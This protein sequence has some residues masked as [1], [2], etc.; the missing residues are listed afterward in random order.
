MREISA[1]M[2]P[3]ERH[4]CDKE[5]CRRIL[6]LSEYRDAKNIFVYVSISAEV[7]TDELILSML[8]DGKNVFVPLC[9]VGGAMEAVKISDVSELH[10][11]LYGIC[12]PPQDNEHAHPESLDIIIVPAVAYSYGGA[13]LGRGG[14]YYDRYINRAKGVTTIGVCR[15]NNLLKTMETEAHDERVDII[16]TESRE[17]RV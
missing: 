6:S 11:G 12:E 1:A 10:A 7:A 5:I 15:E 9:E 17:I 3:S 4:H 8:R 13:R 2:E 14:G 16:I